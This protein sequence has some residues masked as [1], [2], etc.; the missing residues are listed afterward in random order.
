MHKHDEK[1]VKPPPAKGEI[2]CSEK[3]KKC[4]FHGNKKTCSQ[5]LHV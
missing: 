1:G 3:G 2:D 5:R 4:K